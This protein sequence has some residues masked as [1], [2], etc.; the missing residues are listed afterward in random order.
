MVWI[1]PPKSRLGKWRYTVDVER[2]VTIPSGTSFLE[3][4]LYIP[5]NVKS[6]VLFVHG[7]GSSRF[8]ARNQYV[9][10]VLNAANHATLLFDLL[11]PEEDIID[12]R[13][14]EFRFDIN[15]LASRLL[16]VVHWCLCELGPLQL[17][18]GYFGASTGAAA[19]LVA[20]AQ[21]PNLVKA[22]VSRGGRPDLAGEALPRVK[23]PTL[24]IV[25][26]ND[27]VVIEL[28][29]TAKSQITPICQ[30]ELV[31]RATHLFEEPGAL[32]EVARMAREWFDL[33]LI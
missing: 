1:K 17:P 3:G 23:A 25:G 14:R 6:I 15:L 4:I 19:A 13:T 26:G 22:V 7:S 2:S 28:N 10:Q 9:A 20:A 16:D 30:L 21:E 11:T 12:N 5:N 33:Y 8:S 24:L 29:Q 32:D 18:I 31:P 27:E